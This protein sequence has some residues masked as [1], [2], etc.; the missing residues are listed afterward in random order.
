MRLTID[1]FGDVQLDRRMLR[2]AAKAD[3]FSPAFE[4]LADDFLKIERRQFAT[5]GGASG[6][7]APLAPST[8]RFKARMGYDPR[9]LHRTRVMRRSLTRKGAPGAV[10]EISAEEMRVGTSVVSDDGRNFP[11]PRAHQFGTARMPRRRVVEFTRA[12]RRRWIKVLQRFLWEK[13]IT[14]RVT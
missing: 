8:V 3:D 6:G 9:I 14:G 1:I 2:F 7:W 4:D 10:R 13:G 12:D 11:Y 5:Q